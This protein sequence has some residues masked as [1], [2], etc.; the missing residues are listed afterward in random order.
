[1]TES[2]T[3]AGA[4]QRAAP[5]AGV[6]PLRASVLRVLHLLRNN[7]EL[8]EVEEEFRNDPVLSYRLLKFVNSAANGFAR[9]IASF[10]QAITV[11][12]YQ[13]LY[14][15]MVVL[16]VAADD[17]P[18]RAQ[19]VKAALLRGRF[20]ELVGERH[21]RGKGAQDLFMVGVLSRL[22]EVL[23]IPMQR[24]L[25]PLNV[26]EEVRLALIERKG[27]YAHLLELAEALE[28]VDE[29][30]VDTWISVNVI[31]LGLLSESY[32]RASDWVDALPL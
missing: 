13:Q 1:M 21:L 4:P 24:V 18:E 23:G 14:R 11:I 3:T 2:R 22:D 7:A 19:V 6:A 8:T 28:A 17:R 25:A 20:L 31:D 12:G 10:R 5:P 9:E 29:V 27:F 30:A 32:S 15:W 16:L 26:S